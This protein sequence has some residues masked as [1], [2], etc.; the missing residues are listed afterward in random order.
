MWG[1]Q[2]VYVGVLE[3]AAGCVCGG[4]HGRVCVWGCVRQGVCA[5]VHMPDFL[6]MCVCMCVVKLEGRKG[7]KK[8]V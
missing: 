2:G 6:C 4:S 5:Y 1:R 7:K 3:R 8:E